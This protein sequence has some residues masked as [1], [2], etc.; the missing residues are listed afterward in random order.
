MI[1]LVKLE[2]TLD[3]AT[4]Y[5]TLNNKLSEIITEFNSHPSIQI[6]NHAQLRIIV[7]DQNEEIIGTVG[8]DTSLLPY[9]IPQWLPLTNAGEALKR[10][11]DNTQPPRVL[12]M[13]N[14]EKLIPVPEVTERSSNAETGQCP[15]DEIFSSMAQKNNS[16][17]DNIIEL[18]NQIDGK[19]WKFCKKIHEAYHDDIHKVRQA[20]ALAETYK[21]KNEQISI[22]V[23]ELENRLNSFEILYKQEKYQREY[24]EN[25]VATITQDFEELISQESNKLNESNNQINELQ[26]K[27]KNTQ[28]ALES[29]FLKI[30]EYENQ[31]DS[32]K[33]TALINKITDSAEK[34]KL[35]IL[36]LLQEKFEDS[37]FQRTILKEKYEKLIHEK[38]DLT[39]I[40][41]EKCLN[42]EKELLEYK[43]NQANLNSKLNDLETQLESKTYL[44]I[45][46]ESQVEQFETQMKN[47]N[48]EISVKDSEVKKLKLKAE[49]SKKN[50]ENT[51]DLLTQQV[52]TLSEKLAT[53]KQ[54]NYE[55]E[56]MEK[57]SKL[58]DSKLSS[59]NAD[60]RFNEY[61]RN[62]GVEHKFERV[63]EGVYTF[64][65]KKV[66]ITIKN[67]YLVCRVGGGYMMI[68]E[69]L[70]LVVNQST[71]SDKEDL[72]K[73]SS[74]LSPGNHSNHKRSITY[75]DSE[76]EGAQTERVFEYE[77]N[78]SNPI[79]GLKENL[80]HSPRRVRLSPACKSRSFTPLRQ[81]VVKRIFK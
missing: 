48:T 66:S 11:P 44:I 71:K 34:Q 12:V 54:K 53:S 27:L 59:D 64:G 25:Q 79:N 22:L 32:L 15:F 3:N 40:P 78:Y 28:E 41:Q 39:P 70:K 23:T 80:D 67:G 55:L 47:F 5:V 45:K 65:S 33:K 74:T 68:E 18:T 37:E 58:A 8:I 19:K 50:L 43:E 57:D 21:L 46:L 81:N 62:Y 20:Q 2:G 10:L 6:I 31:I 56:H 60:Q 63:A 9:D 16:L 26:G 30:K 4:C 14:S 77:Y 17:R 35:Q 51:V 72:R 61:I 73:F 76:I 38:F 52:R 7:K 49:K 75:L 29:N 1:S 24:L 36:S 42:F 69:F 13:Y